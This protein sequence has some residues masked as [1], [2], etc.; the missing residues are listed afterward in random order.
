MPQAP[1]FPFCGPAKLNISIKPGDNPAQ[2]I[3]FTV[4]QD[5]LS[6]KRDTKISTS[7]EWHE[8]SARDVMLTS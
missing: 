4:N 6:W 8:V 3:Q 2:K 5:Y 7:C 1:V